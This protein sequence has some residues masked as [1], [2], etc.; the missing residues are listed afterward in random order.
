MVLLAPSWR[1]L[2]RLLKIVEE[3]AMAIDTTFN[4]Y[5]TVCMIFSPTNKCKSVGDSFPQFRL[6]GNNL[7]FVPIFKYLGHIIDNNCLMI[8]MYRVIGVL[9]GVLQHPQAVGEVGNF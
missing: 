4:T 6:A 2:Q 8:L 9:L 7:S 1:G 3:A 5:K